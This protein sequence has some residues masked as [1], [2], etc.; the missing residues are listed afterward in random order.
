MVANHLLKALLAGTAFIAAMP[1]Y[2]QTGS[3]V[4]P[5]TPRGEEASGSQAGPD[6]IVTATRRAESLQ[7]TPMTVNVVGGQDLKKYNLFDFKDVQALTP[8]LQLTNDDGRSNSA[9]LRG[10]TFDP[11]S[12]SQPAVDVFFNEIP[13][14]PQTAFTSIYDISQIEVLRGPQGLYRGRSSPAGSITLTTA[15]ANLHKN[16]GYVQATGTSLAG[17]NFQGAAS[18]VLKPDVLAMR[19]A[20]DVDG[21]RA[22]QVRNVSGER[23]RNRTES[24]RLSLS[25]QPTSNFHADLMYQYLTSDVRPFIAAFG[26]GNQPSLLDPTRSGPALTLD[27]RRSVTEGAPRFQNNTNLVTLHAAYD[28]GGA[29]LIYNG[30]YQDAKLTQYR[31]QDVAN[32]VPNYQLPQTVITPYRVWSNELRLESQ[33]DGPFTWFVSGDY[34]HQSDPVTFDQRNDQLLG[35]AFTPIPPAFGVV[36]V[37]VNGGTNIK[38]NVYSI[39]GSAGY[40]FTPRLK[41]TAGL[42]YT[43]ND[44][45]RTQETI[46]TAAGTTTDVAAPLM[47]YNTRYLT[48]GANLAYQVTPDV[49]MYLSY[50]RSVRPGVD[51]VGV[52][53]PLDARYLRTPNETSDGGEFG[54]KTTML[55]G[56]LTLNGDVFY[57]KFKNYIAF[58]PCLTS[59]SSGVP[60]VVDTSC[61]PL[62]TH[63][64][65]ISKG[66]EIELAAHPS[67]NFDFGL[68]ASYADAHYDHAQVYCND[69]N[70]DGIPDSNGTP[71]V[72]GT[73]QIATCT[74]N[75]RLAQVPKFNL[76]GNAELRQPI[77][78]DMQGF[79]RTLVTYRPGFYSQ[80]DDYHFRAYTNIALYL[81]LRGEDSKWEFSV[82]AKNLLDQTRA[83]SVSQGIGQYGTVD[84]TNPLAPVAGAP[85]DSGY[86]TAVISPP[87]EFGATIAFH[88]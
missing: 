21:S 71:S 67:A 49:N 41:L 83:T 72:P 1:G 53:V 11:D 69:Y 82:F 10:I 79:I 26:D 15:K 42:R 27:D 66:A 7:D 30:G 16:E 37:Q 2:A 58:E 77:G 45:S 59:N 54:V 23:G 51:A 78:N 74:R 20:I 6:I 70:G 14:D 75:D 81:G 46:I 39:A 87:R 12:G 34:G 3:A 28:F 31:D 17:Y 84:Y 73:E 4:T 60:G 29:S 35:L 33:D 76:S 47:K 88:W 65:A 18:L 43:W 61:A 19:A 57:Q 64:N 8:G 36:P 63:G 25:Y 85:F 80:A 68:S 52:S 22:N 13:V 24:A 55:N 40:E 56:A 44:T 86:R 9:T 50:G 48:G 62:P 5:A 32:A 38:V